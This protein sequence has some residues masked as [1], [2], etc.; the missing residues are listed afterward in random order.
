MTKDKTNNAEV[1]SELLKEEYSNNP[2][3]E[4]HMINGKLVV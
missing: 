2:T 4:F 3:V 1:N